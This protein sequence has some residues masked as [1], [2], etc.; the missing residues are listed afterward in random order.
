MENLA[1]KQTASAFVSTF[2][3]QHHTDLPQMSRFIRNS[4]VNQVPF[5]LKPRFLALAD[6]LQELHEKKDQLWDTALLQQIADYETLTKDLKYK[7][8]RSDDLTHLFIRLLLSA[9]KLMDETTW[10]VFLETNFQKR[11]S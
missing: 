7:A 3:T 4:F 1:E 9:S 10:E 2:A 8:E 5:E 6:F 11:N